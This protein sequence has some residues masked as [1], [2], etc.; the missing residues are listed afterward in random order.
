MRLPWPRSKDGWL[1]NHQENGNGPAAPWEFDHPI[2]GFAETIRDRLILSFQLNGVN[3]KPKLVAVTGCPQGAG[4]ST[5]SAGIAAAL[6]ETGD[7]KV[8]LVDMNVGRP[9]VHPFFQGAPAC[10]LAEALVGAPA[11]A[12]ENLYLAVA[13]PSNGRRN[14][15]IPKRFYEMMPHLKASEFDYIIFDMPPLNQTSVTL[16]CPLGWTRCWS[17]LKLKEAIGDFV[18]RSYAE[19]LACRANASVIFNKVRPYTPKWLGAEK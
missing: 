17:S 1:A 11:P 18:K 4:T 16:A 6:S 2:R 15:V 10:S 3:H 8:L 9:E 12:G 19:L 14:H 13:T 5:I 7:G